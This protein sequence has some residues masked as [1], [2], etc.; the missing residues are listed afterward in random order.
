MHNPIFLKFCPQKPHVI[1]NVMYA[2][3]CYWLET[4]VAKTVFL[5]AG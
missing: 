4:H 5:N 3:L 1:L 2:C